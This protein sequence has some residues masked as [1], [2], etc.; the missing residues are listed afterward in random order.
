MKKALIAGLIPAALVVWAAVA[1]AQIP[2]V[3]ISSPSFQL[4]NEE[5]VFYCPIDSSVV[6]ATW[7]DFRLGYRRCGIGRSTDGGRP[8]PIP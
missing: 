4:Q 5:Q 1:S 6:V 2:N 3:Q 7:R 8:G